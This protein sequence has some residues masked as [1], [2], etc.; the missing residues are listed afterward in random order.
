MKEGFVVKDAKEG[1]K[2][3]SIDLELINKYTR[4]A[5]QEDEIYVFNLVLCDNDLDRDFECFSLG[6]LNK[7]Q[8]LFLGKTG[9]FDHDP[10][11]TNQMARIFFTEVVKGDEKKTHAGEDYYMLKARA[12]MIKSEKN[13]DLILEIDGGIKKEV[14]VGC[15]VEACVCTV[16]GAN[17]KKSKCNHVKGKE[18]VKNGN[19]VLCY[20][21]L[22]N[23]TDAYE[24]SFVAVPAQKMAG[25]VKANR[26]HSETEEVMLGGDVVEFRERFKSFDGNGAYLSKQC[27]GN[28][29]SALEELE[30]VRELAGTFKEELI[31]SVEGAYILSLPNLSLATIKSIVSKMT[32]LELQEFKKANEKDL[33]S[34][35]YIQTAHKDEGNKPSDHKSFYI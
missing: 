27:L 23:P 11:G 10:K 21:I 15:N 30:E 33:A 8:K 19:K 31:K 32:V 16:C 24:W 25:V 3:S 4:R 18:Y 29:H 22:E 13:K 35:I 7:L 20:G 34:G 1:L 9:I 2:E 26:E 17:I 14:S 28:I 5:L 12:Y 6:A